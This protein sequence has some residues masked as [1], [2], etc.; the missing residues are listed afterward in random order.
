MG[1]RVV[2][3]V[4][5]GHDGSWEAMKRTSG[6][7]AAK[8][9]S[10]CQAKVRAVFRAEGTAAEEARGEGKV[11]VFTEQKGGPCDLSL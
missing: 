8:Q 9:G 5:G 11:P 7:R 1:G 6:P 4:H 3:I 10:A 2:L